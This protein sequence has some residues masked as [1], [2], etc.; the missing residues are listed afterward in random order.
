[1]AHV[2]TVLGPIHS[3]EMGITAMHEHLMWGLPGWD[4]DPE[5]W[6]NISEAFTECYNNLMDFKLRGGQTYVD[7]SY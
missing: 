2:N 4:Y 5:F 6:I 7:C 1:M 3:E